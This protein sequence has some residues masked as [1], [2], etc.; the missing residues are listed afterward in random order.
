MLA[1]LSALS[2][3]IIPFGSLLGPFLVWQFRK[4]DMPAVVAHAR[5][6]LNF[7]LSCILYFL[8]CVPLLFVLVGG[9]LMFL[10]AVADLVCVIIASIK[11]ND[12]KPWSYPATI[13]FLK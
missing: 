12:G 13:R 7:Q 9:P 1:H 6:S 11:A 10:I 4:N 3:Y 5:M 8:I 2:G